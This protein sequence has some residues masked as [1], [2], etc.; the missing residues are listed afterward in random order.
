MS[1]D[2]LAPEPGEARLMSLLAQMTLAEKAALMA[3]QDFWT[4]PAIPRLG[5]PSLRMSDGPTGLRSVNSEPATVFP[6]ATALAATWS[7][8]LVERVGAAIAREAIA[9]GVDVLL[10]PGVNIQRTPLGGRNFEY[11]SED[12]HLSAR[13]GIAY[14]NGVQG[15]GVGASVKHFA[16]NNQ[17]HE[18]LRTNVNVT[19]RA[20]REI[21]LASFEPIIREA[22]P[23]TVMSAYNRIHGT[24]ASEND[25]LLNRV[26]KTE[27]E[28]DGAV[29]SDWGAT[30]STAPSA[31]HGLDIEMPGPPRYYGP[32][33]MAAVEAGAVS[34]A[35]VDAHVLR[36]LR[37]I[38]RCGLLD[39]NPKTARAELRSERHRLLAREAAAEAMVLL[40]NEGGLLPL[41]GVGTLALIGGLADYPAIQGGGSSQVT[42][43]R[44]VTP[45]EAIEAAFSPATRIIF[46]RGIDPEPRAPVIDARLLRPPE[47]ADVPGLEATYFDAAGYT[48]EIRLRQIEQHFA[49]L[50]FGA[51]AQTPDDASFSVEW[52]GTLRPR[53]SGRHVFELTHSS[54]DAELI[55]DGR[56][57]VSDATPRETEMLF[58]MLRLNRRRGEIDLDRGRSYDILIRY[59]QPRKSSV[60]GFNIFNVCLREPAPDVLEAI[61]AARS[62]DAAVV[63]VGAGTTSETEGADRVSM[64]LPDDQ[65]ALVEAVLAVNPNTVVVVN[66]GAPVEMPWADKVPAII[67]MWLPGQ[68]GAL[69][70][71]DILEGAV[72]PS[73]KLPVTFPRRYEDN[74]TALYYPGGLQSDYGEGLF[75]GYR[76]YDRAGVEPLFPFGHGLSYT[77][78]EIFAL[79]GPRAI[80]AGETAHVSVM[81]ANTGPRAGA[82]TVQVYVQ[83]CASAESKPLRQLRAFG[84]V[85]LGPGERRKLSFDLGP[86]AFSWFDPDRDD[87]AIVPGRYRI[88]AGTSSRNLAA[89]CDLDI[90]PSA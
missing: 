28:F 31:N 44:I 34:E 18:R 32:A 17:E 10:A 71:A 25:W 77:T 15:E 37:L 4:L 52:R 13:I 27:W 75:V 78:F 87:W 41:A 19:M 60:A 72:N 70:L 20:L 35:T 69:A 66:T 55:V 38:A 50:G 76:Y 40:R 88:H 7:P 83:D 58:M 22:R 12:P 57:L 16:A 9:H 14:V 68:E 23:W 6:V 2:T 62:A 39:G 3:G 80:V 46:A 74:P 47:G 79:E 90:L 43:D 5:I 64:R 53:Y 89:V 82:E 48:G 36:I 29:V 26:L 81:V 85:L 45:R 61:E 59:S 30:H 11:Y 54:P 84:K 42:P 51:A 8:A 86:R 56:A 1:A 65:N 21:Y 67:Q 24:Y 63:F 33:L 49:R 73:G